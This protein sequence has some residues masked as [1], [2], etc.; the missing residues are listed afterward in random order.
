[1]LVAAALA[2]LTT[3]PAQADDTPVIRLAFA[4]A[5][6]DNRPVVDEAWIDAQVERANRHWSGVPVRFRRIETRPL[7]A[8]F[9]RIETR[10]DRD[11][12]ADRLT[13]GAINVRI[14][15]FL[16]DVD[17]PG[18]E[19]RGVH[20][21]L[22]ADRSHHYIILSSIAGLDV[23]AHE[24]GHFLG[25]GHSKVDDNLMSYTRTGSAVFLDE[26]QLAQARRALADYI[27]R[28]ELIGVPGRGGP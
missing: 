15:G 21:H 6:V 3:A 18:R 12:A 24:L 8:R 22:R 4:V 9:A 2:S 13:T 25:N 20:W 23:L 1:M 16:A 26:A 7:V 27:A 5:Q 10:A 28:G 17:E 19:R 11:A 14:T